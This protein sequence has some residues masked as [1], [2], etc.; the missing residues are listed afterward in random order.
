MQKQT[1]ERK[2]N[3]E[4]VG[5]ERELKSNVSIFDNAQLHDHGTS[6]CVLKAVVPNWC[7][8]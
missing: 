4:A 3:P 1:Q 2:A 7:A 6:V 5:G 8:L